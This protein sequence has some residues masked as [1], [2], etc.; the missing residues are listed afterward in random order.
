VPRPPR[1]RQE[2][3]CA[4]PGVGTN[5][6]LELNNLNLA[7]VL[8]GKRTRKLNSLFKR[9]SGMTRGK[10]KPSCGSITYH[11]FINNIFDL[12]AIFTYDAHEFHSLTNELFNEGRH[13]RTVPRL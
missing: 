11:Y 10:N 13:F 3:W 5:N 7:R 9:F 12:F 1:K 4:V 8:K 6:E 2:T